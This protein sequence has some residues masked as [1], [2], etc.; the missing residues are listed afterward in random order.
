MATLKPLALILCKFSDVAIPNLPIATFQNFMS[1]GYG[2]LRDY[3][4]DVSWGGV[5]ITT[6]VV[7]GWWEMQYSYMQDGNRSRGDFISEARRL[8]AL[9]GVDLSKYYGVM[10]FPNANVDGGNAG[11]T[12]MV[13]CV[14][15]S[16]GQSQWRWCL[17]CQSMAYA[18]F[19][20][21]PCPAGGTHDQS[22]SASYS[23]A[24]NES[25]G[26]PSQDNWRWCK[27]CQVLNFGGNAPGP[28]A[29]SGVHDNSGSGNY[30][31]RVGAFGIAWQDKWAWCKKCQTLVYS[32]NPPAP[33]AAGGVHDT[34]ASEDY[35][36]VQYWSDLDATNAAHETG[37]GFG[38]QHSW[39]A[40]PETEYGNQWDIMS[41]MAVL[42]Y[43]G[44]TYSPAGPGMD[45]A[46]LDFLGVLP[47]ELTWHQPPVGSFGEQLQLLTLANSG[48]VRLGWFAAKM[49]KG[50]RTYYVEYRQ[51]TGW[52]RAFPRQA[53]FINE[54]RIW[55]WCRKCQ[56]L[57]SL[58][59]GAQGSCAAGGVHDLTG[60]SYYTL[61]RGTVGQPALPGQS[62]WRWCNKCQ[63]LNFAGGPSH[64][65]CPAGGQHAY[66]GSGNYTLVHETPSYGQPDWRWCNK[67]QGLSYA[68]GAQ[69][70]TCPAGGSHAVQSD[71]YSL[72]INSRNSFLLG[73]AAGICDWQPGKVFVA[74]DTSMCVVV[75]AFGGT[76]DLPTAT[77]T[78]GDA[79]SN[80]RWCSKCQ[81]LAYGGESQGVCPAGGQHEFQGS[82]DYSLLHDVAATTGQNQW[83]WCSKCQGLN[84]AG[85]ALGVCPAGGA[86]NIASYDYVL[87]HDIPMSDT[88]QNWRWCNKCQGLMYAGLSQG[89]CPAGGT[90]STASDDYNMI[91]V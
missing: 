57:T 33:C 21:G 10:A 60:S 11:G 6:S 59:S 23:L 80:W 22:Q 5:D 65:V 4:Y 88:Q 27:K 81:G 30:A 71:N 48:G 28:C 83:R 45:A 31:L 50:D 82:D 74:K 91:N 77:I 16:W 1:S 58:S 90:H 39:L 52:D 51:P 14:G 25:A 85:G 44:S 13:G 19:G 9:N 89:V 43:P 12:D 15:G 42:S 55:Q 17:K 78:V 46:N 63:A 24:L 87:L 40:T 62:L 35:S 41:A 64:G 54:V 76:A 84:Y 75:H 56:E 68:G 3:W 66:Q 32:G 8:A 34:S 7:L 18:G 70:G 26:A 53:I 73:D 61:L 29:A 69:V 86:H 79:Q 38:L 49:P 2:G 37:H 47:D 72:L 20:T 67:C 36:V